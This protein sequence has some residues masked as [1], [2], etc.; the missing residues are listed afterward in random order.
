MNMSFDPIALSHKHLRATAAFLMSLAED[1]AHQDHVGNAQP[2]VAS[3]TGN[4]AAGVSSER[5]VPAGVIGGETTLAEVPAEANVATVAKRQRRTKAEME[6]DAKPDTEAVQ[7]PTP[8]TAPS[9]DAVRGALQAF[10]ERRGMT[11]GMALLKQF[12]AGRISELQT[13]QFAAFIAEC[14]K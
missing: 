11:D 3:N 7:A 6:A 9:I 8:V 5:S 1:V 14:G 13:E 12:N 2:E 4:H 10:T